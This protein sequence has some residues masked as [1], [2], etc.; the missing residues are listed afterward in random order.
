MAGLFRTSYGNFWVTDNLAVTIDEFFEELDVLVI[1]EHGAR[2]DAIDPDR[3]LFL[4]LELGLG[5]LPRLGVLFSKTRGKGHGPVGCK[6]RW[7]VGW[8]NSEL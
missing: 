1:D 5:P 8:S 6:S 3:I 7:K 4:G 2:P